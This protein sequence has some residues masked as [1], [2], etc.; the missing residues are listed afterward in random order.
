M[1]SGRGQRKA[2][3]PPGGYVRPAA[4]DEGGLVVT[5][6]GE[7]GGVE[8]RYDFSVLPGSRDLLRACAAGFER[9]AGPDRNWRAAAT[10]RTG[11]KVIRAF[12][13]HVADLDHPPEKAGEI[14]PAVWASWRLS[15]PDTVHGRVGISVTRQWL[16]HVPGIAAETIAVA[17]RRIPKRPDPTEAAYTREE[18]ERIRAVAAVTFNS[19]LTRIR[20]GRAHL[21]RWHAGEFA[22]RSADWL[23]GEA[24]DSVLRT[25]DVP[26]GRRQQRT[27]L[28]RYVRACGGRA[29]EQTWGR[30][31]LTLQEAYALA[32]LLICDQGWNR[33]VLDQMPVPDDAPGMG[34]NG[35]EIYRTEIYKR[36]RPAHLRYSSA[37]L[38]D[39]GP[40]SAGR[41]MRQA[42]EATEPARLTLELLGRPTDRLLISRR[43]TDAG[44][45]KGVFH[46]GVPNQL[47]QR[48]WATRSGLVEDL[49]D[50]TAAF[51]VSLRRLRR[52]VQVLVRREPAQNT[53]AT[54]ESVYLLRDP[55]VRDELEQIVVRGLTDAAA[56]A[57]ATVQMRIHLGASA[58][59]L[60]DVIDDPA[61]LRAVAEGALDTATGAC[62]DFTASPFSEPGQ[63]CT[64]SFLICLACRNAVATRRHLP[65][66]AYLHQA[67]EALRAI[68]QAPVWEQD[69]KIHYL[70]LSHLLNGHTTA[71][72]RAE[73]TRRISED[74]RLLIDRLLRRGYDAS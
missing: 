42:I 50:G 60:T 4:F 52:T 31:L 66:L 32:V 25:G 16:P 51:T 54:H 40:G 65:R 38:V 8:G 29:A 23:I 61:K 6:F 26:R 44:P 37:N 15:R 46:L 72:E 59:E 70:R 62:L 53:P 49:S 58:D 21:G 63:P 27:V 18:F 33:A 74:D 9:L 3:L 73:A 35:L 68:V 57:A 48:Q 41:L 28:A 5:V 22:P 67:L 20:Q 14:T 2:A 7:S 34:E 17:G 43:A 45:G 19:A 24:L 71:A 11:Y 1:G 64:A 30:L 10:C 12:L 69:W 39:H 56:H 13:R 47:V 55:A 36:R